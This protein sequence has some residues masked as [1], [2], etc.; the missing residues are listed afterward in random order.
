[1]RFLL[2]ILAGW[3][4]LLACA[5]DFDESTRT[6]A[7][8]QHMQVFE[9][10]DGSA[11]LEEVTSPLFNRFHP[12]LKRVL[13][14]GYSNSVFWIKVD[15]RYAPRVDLAPRHWLL[16][17]AYPPMDHIDLYLADEQGR[18]GLAQRTGDA[19]PYSSR[20]IRQNNF[21][22][23]IPFSN[24]RPQTLY[25][26]VH[27][28]GSVQVPLALWSAD[29]YMEEQPSRLYLF[30]LIYGVL[31]GMLVYNLF[32]YLS[33]RDKAYLYYILYIAS[34]GLYQVSVNGAGVE[35]FWPDNPWWAN[36]ATPF[37]IGASAFFGSQFA[38]SFLQTSKHGRWLDRLLRALMLCGVAAMLLALTTEYGLALRFATALALA[39]TVVVFASA[40]VVWWRGLRMARYFIIAW[41][42]FLVG[43]IVNTLMVL[44]HL[45]NVFITMYAS[46]LGSAL[47]V[48]LL[49]LAL[50]DRI[51]VLREQQARVLAEASEKREL[52][53]QQLA[54][55]NRLKDEFL[56]TVTHEL[57][58][59]MNGVIGSLELMQTVPMGTELAHYQRTAAG[60]AR[61]MMRMVEDILTLT[62]LRA[63]KL[64][65]EHEPFSLQ[66]LLDSMRLQFARQA[67]DKGLGFSIERAAGAPDSLRGD[68]KKLA[69]CLGCLIDNGIKFTRQGSVDLRVECL[70]RSGD[71]LRLLF[72]I[73]DSG[74]GFSHQDE[75][76]LYQ[77]FYQ[78]DGS[79]T[80]EYGG[81]GIGL[82]ICQQLAELLGGDLHHQSEPGRGSRFELR[83]SVGADR[84]PS[85]A[86]I[87]PPSVFD[88]RRAAHDCTVLL[89]NDNSL[90]QL[91]VR[92]M[93]LKL[94][95]GVRTADDRGAAL[96]LLR[97]ER[98][99]AV[100]LAGSMPVADGIAFF[101]ELQGLPGCAG[102]PVLAVTEQGSAC[103]RY[104]AVGIARC[105]NR[106]VRFDELQGALHE[107]VLSK[108]RVEGESA[109]S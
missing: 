15:L 23:D 24:Y 63:G 7:L 89:I 87:S 10:V 44:G 5:I 60:S 14:A 86:S 51:N 13:N 99:D 21:L 101:H 74:I 50:A 18:F 93:L 55:S 65:P 102:L 88:T 2:I 90:D 95:Y 3:L 4:P 109:G 41:T 29:A 46:Q 39:F 77:R 98:F 83:V 72:T 54:N 17:L 35:F 25:L 94:G 6:L 34:F 49:S 16:E 42:A 75:E 104:L 40:I 1:M 38:R 19:L 85:Q 73:S 9:D 53:N 56:A 37:L 8:G 45:P 71:S 12:N 68:A 26:R 82:A 84:W 58:T 97:R 103:P 70:E 59:P 79:I 100:L 31:L 107:C 108:A 28:Q 20:Q 80:R 92:G 36:A 11:T 78:V 67:Q 30:G 22:F 52:L 61:D 32:I 91:V 33:V 105:L 106:P 66:A 27:S 96:G 76:T 47:E 48:G 57:R 64:Y 62:G 69:L 43:G 81:L